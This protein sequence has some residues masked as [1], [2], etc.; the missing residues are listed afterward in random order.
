[1]QALGNLSSYCL[2]G[3]HFGFPAAKAIHL[4]MY[5]NININRHLGTSNR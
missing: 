2:E 3:Y 4:L 1:M 5:I